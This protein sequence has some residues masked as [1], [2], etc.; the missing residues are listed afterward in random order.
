MAKLEGPAA[1]PGTDAIPLRLVE[2]AE[3]QGFIV[4][5]GRRWRITEAGALALRRGV[6][7]IPPPTSEPSHRSRAHDRSGKLHMLQRLATLKDGRRR[8]VL[9]GDQTE[10]GLRLSRDFALGELRQRVTLDWSFADL[11]TAPPRGDPSR[12][13]EM[14][15]G[16]E[17]ARHRFRRA[18]S[19]VGPEF[20]DLLIE[21]CCFETPLETIEERRGWPARSARLVLALGLQRLARHYGTVSRVPDRPRSIGTWHA[22]SP[23]SG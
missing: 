8:A 22:P 13:A 23:V 1:K 5:D 10:A 21:V 20:A 7:A 9:T 12:A 4:S 3:C 14:S 19:D 6:T 15:D 11:G 17:A 2:R 16:A 18:L